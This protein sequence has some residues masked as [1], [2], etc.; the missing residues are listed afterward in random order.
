MY[1]TD[2]NKQYQQTTGL[3]QR[4]INITHLLLIGVIVAEKFYLRKCVCCLH[5][6][7]AWKTISCHTEKGNGV[8]HKQIWQGNCVE[9]VVKMNNDNWLKTTKLVVSINLF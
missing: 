7:F 8:K 5:V 4:L 2:I 3:I 6:S 1:N 9:D